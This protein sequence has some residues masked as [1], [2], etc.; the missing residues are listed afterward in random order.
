MI[1][2]FSIDDKFQPYAGK[3]QWLKYGKGEFIDVYRYVKI[4][5]NILFE[6]LKS[7]IIKDVKR[8]IDNKSRIKEIVESNY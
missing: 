4:D 6:D 5:E 7:Q 2:N 1:F 8:F 3:K